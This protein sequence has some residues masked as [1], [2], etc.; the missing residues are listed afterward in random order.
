MEA[1]LIYDMQ[2]LHDQPVDATDKLIRICQEVGA[3][4]YLA[5][6]GGRGYQDEGKFNKAG[7]EVIYNEFRHPK[8]EQRWEDKG[9]IQGLSILDLILNNGKESP[10][11]MDAMGE[12]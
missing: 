8:Y 5:G 4:T 9:F 10:Q 2:I 11:I 7:I 6:Q 1:L 12:R 3:D